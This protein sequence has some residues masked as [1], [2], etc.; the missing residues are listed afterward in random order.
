MLCALRTH[1]HDP[2]VV[3][4]ACSVLHNLATAASQ[5]L[6]DRIVR[7]HGA[8]ACVLAAIRRHI[9][10]A[11][12]LNVACLA[13]VA[14]SGGSS[15]RCDKIVSDGGL[16]IILEAMN[17]HRSDIFVQVCVFF[18]CECVFVMQMFHVG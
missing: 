7:D 16:S 8:S 5:E 14:F 6:V 12:V 11:N 9:S 3:Q 13:L 10:E 1:Y 4:N 15:A 18:V 17:A 2:N